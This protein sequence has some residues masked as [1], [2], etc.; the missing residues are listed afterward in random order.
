MEWRGPGSS[1]GFTCVALTSPADGTASSSLVHLGPPPAVEPLGR[2]RDVFR[3]GSSFS[4]EGVNPPPVP[5]RSG[6][7]ICHDRRDA[8]NRMAGG[9]DASRLRGVVLWRESTKIRGSG[10]LV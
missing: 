3:P 9:E 5:R 7:K 10:Q 8:N 6:G 2:V 4:L 1:C